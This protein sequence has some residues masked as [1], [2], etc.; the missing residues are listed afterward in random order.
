MRA[1]VGD[2]QARAL[3]LIPRVLD[4][5]ERE[6]YQKTGE[7][8]ITGSEGGQYRINTDGCVGNVVPLQDVRIGRAFWKR[9]PKLSGLCAHPQMA[10]YDS[11]GRFIGEL[12]MADAHIAQILAIKTDEENFLRTANL[13]YV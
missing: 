11:M 7:I 8:V 12:P 5:E 13:Y 10:Q 1:Y 9:A 4:P 2:P 3:S 6:H